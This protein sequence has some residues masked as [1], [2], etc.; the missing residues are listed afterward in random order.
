MVTPPPKDG[1]W[2][3]T[4]GLHLGHH[5]NSEFP[6]GLETDVLAQ[7]PPCQDCSF[8]QTSIQS[9]H[10]GTPYLTPGPSG[11]W[12]V[13]KKVEPFSQAL[14]LLT[15]KQGGWL[16]G[17]A[18]WWPLALLT[19]SEQAASILGVLSKNRR[20]QTLACLPLRLCLPP[21]P[22]PV[23]APRDCP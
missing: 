13:E 10:H 4:P 17:I 16:S 18:I 23:A 9:L 1:V 5:P 15:R 8:R 22:P 2:R 11:E 3:L 20:P 21:Y 14:A 19:H 12:I 6:M 7:P